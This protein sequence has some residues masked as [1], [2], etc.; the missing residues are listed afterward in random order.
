MRKPF[1]ILVEGLVSE[2]SRGDRR[3]TFPNDF[4]GQMVLWRAFAQAMDFTADNFYA[5][6]TR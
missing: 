6:G 4:S 2:S 5:A 3:L 1:D